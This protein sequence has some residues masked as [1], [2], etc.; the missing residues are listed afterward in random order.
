MGGI[1]G[2][3]QMLQT[4][5]WLQMKSYPLSNAI[6]FGGM[7]RIKKRI[8]KA[9]ANEVLC[10]FAGVLEQFITWQLSNLH[11]LKWLL[12]SVHYCW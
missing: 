8:G 6:L 2:I 3:R 11:L 12:Q 10:K 4:V 1:I 5:F 9:I 7:K